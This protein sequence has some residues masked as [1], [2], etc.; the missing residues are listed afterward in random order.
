VIDD[1]LE[2][3]NLVKRYPL[4]KKDGQELRNYLSQSGVSTVSQA[5]ESLELYRGSLK[6]EKANKEGKI[7][8]DMAKA[9][10]YF[11]QAETVTE[12]IR[13]MGENFEGLQIDLGKAEDDIFFV[14]PPFLYLA[15]YAIRYDD[16]YIQ[17][18][19]DVERAKEKLAYIPPF[20]DDDKPSSSEEL[21]KRPVHLM[22]AI[23]SK[24]KE[25]DSVILLDVNDGIWPNKNAQ[26]TEEKEGERRVFYVAFTRAKRRI[27]MLVSKRLG[28]RE[29]DRSQFL[30]EIGL[31]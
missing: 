8:G 27:L 7:S 11:L 29:A 17:F 24:G 9:I 1:L 14:D 12:S 5:V 23:R 31:M 16:D 25:F 3:C 21:W 28:N 18:I 20:E 22:T 30:E 6:G 15:E 13:E 10:R 26:T 19:E 2:L 4:S